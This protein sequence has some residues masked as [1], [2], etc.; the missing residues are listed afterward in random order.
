M[1]NFGKAYYLVHFF[2]NFDPI[3]WFLW[4][5]AL[6]LSFLSNSFIVN[7]DFFENRVNFVLE[8]GWPDQIVT[9]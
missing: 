3:W 2:K 8:T 1:A 5:F 6:V 9:I 4:F 7:D